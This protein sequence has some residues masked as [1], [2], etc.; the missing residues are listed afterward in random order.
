MIKVELSFISY[1]N[2]NP[3]WIKKKNLLKYGKLNINYFLY[4]ISMMENSLFNKISVVDFFGRCP[5]SDGGSS[6]LFLIY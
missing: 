5:L 1:A 3:N 4:N 2:K 6:F